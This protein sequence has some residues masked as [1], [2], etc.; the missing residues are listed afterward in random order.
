MNKLQI[1]LVI[2]PIVSLVALTIFIY[3]GIIEMDTIWNNL[4][5]FLLAGIFLPIGMLITLRLTKSHNSSEK[6]Y[7]VKKHTENLIDVFKLVSQ[8]TFRKKKENLVLMLPTEYEE[9]Y[10]NSTIIKAMER[11]TTETDRSLTSIDGIKFH[12]EYKFFGFAMEHLKHKK[13]KD[14]YQHW[15]NAERLIK[16]YNESSKFMGQL[17]QKIRDS[18]SETFPEFEEQEGFSFPEHFF[19][20][21]TVTDYIMYKIWH[22]KED[23]TDSILND[24]ITDRLN[25]EQSCICE[26]GSGINSHLGSIDKE[27][28]DLKR[29]KEMLMSIMT[30]KKI[31]ESLDTDF[32]KKHEISEE[33]DKFETKLKNLI[34]K[35]EDVATIEGKCQSCS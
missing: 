1:I 31:R 11:I 32:K 8:V 4:T 33:H 3:Y 15:E 34:L 23:T 24:L 6:Q 19:K 28:L 22:I 16:E 17:Q 26:K 29:Y 25:H 20:I 9:P 2:I 27:K 5:Y 13:Y 10:S 21:R 18:I 30:D 7:D 35:L 12:K 14:I